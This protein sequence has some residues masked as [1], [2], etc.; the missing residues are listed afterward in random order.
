MLN[1]AKLIFMILSP[2]LLEYNIRETL[3]QHW[4]S[5]YSWSY[6]QRSTGHGIHNGAKYCCLS[7]KHKHLESY[8]T[9]LLSERDG[10][11][12]LTATGVPHIPWKHDYMITNNKKTSPLIIPRQPSTMGSQRQHSIIHQWKRSIAN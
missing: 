12:R 11:I 1:K 7:H 2:N 4:Y 5:Q 3:R 8:I 9:N 6:C 10:R